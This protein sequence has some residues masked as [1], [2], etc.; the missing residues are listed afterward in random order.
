MSLLRY[1]CVLAATVPALWGCL[2]SAA[3]TGVPADP[4]ATYLWG[5]FKGCRRDAY[6][7]SAVEK[8][9]FQM[10]GSTGG[11]VRRLLPGPTLENADPATA[12][13]ALRRACVSGRAHPASGFLLGGH[14]EERGA[15]PPFILMR[16]WRVDLSTQEI[17]YRDHYCRGCDVA[18]TLSTQAAFLLEHPDGAAAAASALPSFCSLQAPPRPALPAVPTDDRIALSIRSGGQ[19]PKSAGSARRPSAGQAQTAAQGKLLEALRQHLTLTGR[20]VTSGSAR[21]ALSVEFLPNGAVQ[22]TLSSAG[23]KATEPLPGVTVG[24]AGCTPEVLFERV[25]KEAGALFDAAAAEL[26]TSG[27]GETVELPLLPQAQQALCAKASAQS[28][29][30]AARLD[31]DPSLSPFFNP[32][33][34]EPVGDVEQAPR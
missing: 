13:G 16:L 29:A 18:R 20:E 30:T 17:A 11:E 33:C 6:L 7:S 12:A 15:A 31:S 27:M 2:P 23:R 28:C 25:V 8:R 9:I 21:Y 3:P 1:G 10:S 4:A 26:K 19:G 5:I 14:V 24:C 22:L 32:Q 34:G